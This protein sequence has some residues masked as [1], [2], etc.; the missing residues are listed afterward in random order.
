MIKKDI[1]DFLKEKKYPEG[2]IQVQADQGTMKISLRTKVDSDE[3][4]NILSK[5]I[6][7]VLIQKG[8]IKTTSEVIEQ[9]VT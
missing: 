1:G 7:S 2:D 4:V 9:S 3:K 5:D 6:Q 8:Y